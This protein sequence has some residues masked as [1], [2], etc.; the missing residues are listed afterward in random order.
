MGTSFSKY[1]N[2]NSISDNVTPS[3]MGVTTKSHHRLPPKDD[4]SNSS[5]NSGMRTAKVS[6]W[7][8]TNCQSLVKEFEE[9]CPSCHG[10]QV[11]LKGQISSDS[12]RWWL[13]RLSPS[14]VSTEK[15]SFMVSQTAEAAQGEE[16]K[17]ED[18]PDVEK[19]FS[20]ANEHCK[21]KNFRPIDPVA[22]VL[23]SNNYPDLVGLSTATSSE[24][25]ASMIMGEH[26]NELAELCL[27]RKASDDYDETENCKKP[28]ECNG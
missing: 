4:I 7:P 1:L 3:T 13:E 28:K 11:T 17:T 27:K 23:D 18:V 10:L 14:T 16:E 8:C 5:D 25:S 12:I 15:V 6:S 2:T 19:L 9:R 21:E 24:S 26:D 22:F 20:D